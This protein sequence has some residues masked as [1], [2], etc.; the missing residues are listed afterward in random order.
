[1][2]CSLRIQNFKSIKE[3]KK[4]GIEIRPLTIITGPNSSGKSNILEAIAF[5][6]QVPRHPKDYTTNVE[7]IV[8]HGFYVNYPDVG[9]VAFR[10]DEKAP[11]RIGL[12][13][14]LYL[15]DQKKI[16][17]KSEKIGY[18]LTYTP[19]TKETEQT[20][21]LDGRVLIKT[22]WLRTESGYRSIFLSPPILTK[23]RP[24]QSTDQ[25]LSH[26]IFIPSSAE[27][28]TAERLEIGETLRTARSCVDTIL[29][30]L[31]RA[32]F[33]ST[34]RGVVPTTGKAQG[35]PKW[36]GK[37]G[38]DLLSLLSFIF[39]RREHFQTAE[40]IRHWASRFG[41]KSMQGG[42]WGNDLIGVDFED[43]ILKQ[44]FQL[45]SASY[46]TRQVLAIITQVLW[47]KRGDTIMLEEPEISLHPEAQVVLQELFAEV[48]KE[49]KQIICSTHS[50]FLVLALSRV[51]K[52][53]LLNL[54]EVAV[55]HVEKDE[56]GTRIKHLE[57]NKHGFVVSGVPSF[58]KVEK[59]LF[60]EWSESLEG[61]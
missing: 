5:L 43:P 47:S 1:M 3:I 36:V 20:I 58:V 18:E 50:P 53:K 9:F 28:K 34:L 57:L 60:Q 56:E 49:G 41:L 55:Y 32:F 59:E 54:N 21:K 46:G 13:F 23:Q 7:S 12:D 35:S 26:E 38:E 52:K 10:R 37:Q 14:P 45:S 29:Q 39:S 48:I 30:R 25:V 15:E 51:I 11:I 22:G 24:Y 2:I 42:W 31:G 27:L 17:V 61:E 6:S 44:T 19:S 8:H 4:D 33:I 16:G 40:R